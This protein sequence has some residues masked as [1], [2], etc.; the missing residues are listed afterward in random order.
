MSK[1]KVLTMWNNDGIN[2]GEILVLRKP[3]ANITAPFDDARKRDIKKLIDTFLAMDEAVGLAAPQIGISKRIIIFRNKEFKEKDWSK[4]ESDYDIL[5]NPRITQIRGELVTM[6]EGCL[7]CP[8][9]QVEVGRFPEIKIR[10]YDQSGRKISKRYTNYLA[11]VVQHEVDH[12]EGKLIIDYEGTMYIPKQRQDFFAR[13]FK[14]K[15][16]VTD[17]TVTGKM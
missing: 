2:E 3:C 1:K 5:I 12:L 8:E 9:I 10:A 14:Q 13:I 7:S 6:A 4:S 16:P 11:R 17:E 15:E